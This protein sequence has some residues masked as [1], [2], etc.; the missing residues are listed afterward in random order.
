M[1]AGVWKRSDDGSEKYCGEA[2][3]AFIA[4]EIVESGT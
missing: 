1:R 2:S 4:E 3:K